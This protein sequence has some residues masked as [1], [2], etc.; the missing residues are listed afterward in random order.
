MNANKHGTLPLTLTIYPRRGYTHWSIVVWGALEC[1]VRT[2]AKSRSQIPSVASNW[3][4]HFHISGELLSCYWPS[5][6]GLF[7]PPLKYLLFVASWY[8]YI[9]CYSLAVHSHCH[10]KLQVWL[11]FCCDHGN[12]DGLHLVHCADN[13]VEDPVLT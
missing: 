5:Y 10:Q 12:F 9:L 1:R 11:E 3:W 2:L 4:T 6:F 13:A 8:L 7:Q